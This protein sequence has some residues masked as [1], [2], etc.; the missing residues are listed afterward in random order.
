MSPDDSPSVQALAPHL[1]DALRAYGQNDALGKISVLTELQLVRV[2]R[3]CQPAQDAAHALRNILDQGLEQLA[4]SD[5]LGADLLARHFIQGQTVTAIGRALDYSERS[6]FTKQRQAVRNLAHIVLQAEQRA[7][8]HS[9]ANEAQRR[10]LDSLPPPTFTRLFGVDTLL[11]R[12]T[13]FLADADRHWLIALEGMGG[14]GKTALARQ[15]VEDLVCQDRFQLVAWITAQQHDFFGGRLYNLDQPALTFAAALDQ[16]ARALGLDPYLERDE[17]EQVQRLRRAIASQPTLLVV[18]N[19]ETAADLTAL[20]KGLGRL[21]RP[22]KVLL[23]TRQRVMSCDQMT[24]LPVRELP[25]G[26]ALAY[27][28]YHSQERN[29]PALLNAAE[30]ELQ[31]LV[32]VT[33][34]NPLAIKLVVGQA[35]VLPLGRILDDLA[36]V[37]PGTHDFFSFI[38]RYSWERL[39]DPARHLLLHMPLLDPRNATWEDLAHISG[40]ALNGYF[41]NALE[42]L[43]AASL[44]NAGWSQGRLIYSIHRL[45]E[46][47]LLSDLIGLAPLVGGPDHREA[48]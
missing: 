8:R 19:L 10:M 6:V 32:A 20:V 30:P 23:T 12:L 34:G 26:D 45:T 4:Q 18:D 39:S 41:R 22:A 38:F 16:M 33:G 36:A 29:V 37:Q 47:F 48:P 44:L 5:S 2:Q 7:R 9:A 43:V 46:Y 13:G 21:V 3:R 17:Q 1:L 31:R 35:Q 28:R 40:V 27:V 24:S 15:A 14:I 11:T 42:E 25:P